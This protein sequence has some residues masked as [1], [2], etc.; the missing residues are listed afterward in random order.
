MK[1]IN[2]CL[3]RFFE[4]QNPLKK[5]WQARWHPDQKNV[6]ML[7]HYHHLVLAFDV[8]NKKVLYQWWEL[9]ADKRGLESAKR[10]LEEKYHIIVK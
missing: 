9:M 4:N 2:E 8:E 10:Y 3:D 7:F 6:M 1:Q 5:K